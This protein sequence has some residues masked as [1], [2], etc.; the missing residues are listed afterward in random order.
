M[1]A[2]RYIIVAAL[3]FAVGAAGTAGA[4]RLFTGKDIKNGSIEV[5]DLSKKARK[6]LKGSRGSA[7]TQG[8]AGLMGSQGAAG[9]DGIN[10]APGA[11]GTSGSTAP[12][13]LLGTVAVSNATG[14]IFGTPYGNCCYVV[15]SATQVPVPPGTALTA[16][17]F[18]VIANASPG[19][20]TYTV[21]LRVNTAD[22]ALKCTIS[23]TN[24][25]CTPGGDPTVALPEGSKLAM[26]IDEAGTTP[27]GNSLSWGFRV[28]F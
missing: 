22:T 13:L 16:R 7:G 24:T 3:A 28:V 15:E 4:A 19:A 20:G 27:D 10:G 9:K 25:S 18:S 5:V 6:A 21:A 8:P 2:S 1:R 11:P 17:D 12:A 26:K 14:T 23:G